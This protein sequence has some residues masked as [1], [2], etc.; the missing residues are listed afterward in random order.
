MPSVRLNVCKH[1]LCRKKHKV[2]T[3][4]DILKRKVGHNTNVVPKKPKP[5]SKRPA[6][7]ISKTA[8]EI[9]SDESSPERTPLHKQGAR[10]GPVHDSLNVASL[11]DSLQAL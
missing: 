6:N 8:P 3:L 7:R 1:S 5:R 4:K 10:K 2:W 9:I 11:P